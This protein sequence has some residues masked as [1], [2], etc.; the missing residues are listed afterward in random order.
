MFV[1]VALAA[2]ID[3]GEAG[4]A[5]AV[6]HGVAST[7]ATVAIDPIAGGVAVLA[8]PGLPTNKVAGCGFGAELDLDALAAIEARWHA[9]GEPVRFELATL[10]P[11]ALHQALLGR[12]YLLEGFEHVLVRRVRAADAVP[13]LAAGVTVEPVTDATAAD[14]LRVSIDGFGHPDHVSPLDPPIDPAVLERIFADLGTAAVPRYLARVDGAP[15]GIASARFADGLVQLCGAATAPRFRRRGVQRALLTTRL[16]DA[17]A[18]GCD[19]AVVTTAPA[20]QS[21][22]NVM[23]IGFAL[24]YARAVLLRAPVGR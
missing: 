7:G 3:A 9:D 10:A 2:R 15:A 17:V 24:A 4:L 6:A 8:R 1:D 19:L 21:Q 20:S 22:A 12:G 14:W 11:P 5:Q 13:A 16:A 18:A 23:R